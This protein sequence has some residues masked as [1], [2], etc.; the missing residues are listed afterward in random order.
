M[1][2]ESGTQVQNYL[3]NANYITDG[4]KEFVI[5]GTVDETWV[6]DESKLSKTYTFEDGTPFSKEEFLRR[7][8]ENP[9]IYQT[10]TTISS[11]DTPTNFAF[12][13]PINAT[14]F[15]VNTSWGDTLYANSP[16]VPHGNGD[17][18]VTAADENGMLNFNDMFIVNGAVFETTYDMNQ[19]VEPILGDG[20]FGEET[21]EEE[22]G[23]EDED[24]EI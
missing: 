10:L 3:E 19:Y 8:N 1:L 16:D 18:V 4:N 21:Y 17:F 7:A 13:L 9:N 6:I 22:Y 5:R 20:E 15:P 14:D 2:P 11:G 23:Y 24:L 12:K